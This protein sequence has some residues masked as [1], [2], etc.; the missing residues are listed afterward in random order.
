[1]SNVRLF[2]GTD[3]RILDMSP[4]E[5]AVFKETCLYVASQL[6]DVFIDLEFVESQKDKFRSEKNPHLYYNLVDKLVAYDEMRRGNPLFQYDSF[7]LTN[8]YAMAE[9]FAKCSF[10]FGE[11]GLI[12]YRMM[13]ALYFAGVLKRIPTSFFSDYNRLERGMH[14]IIDFAEHQKQKP[15]VLAFDNISEDDLLME[16]GRP[17][18]KGALGSAPLNLRYS[19]TI[20]ISA[21]EIFPVHTAE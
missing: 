3:Q 1:M 7:C 8:V 11:V 12:P 20:D 19:G 18:T 15:V 16:D 21:A 14:K 2:H 9:K 17:L 6:R 5:R 10:A 4:E 13:E